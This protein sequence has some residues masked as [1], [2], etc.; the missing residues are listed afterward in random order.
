MNRK[1]DWTDQQS[2]VGT[3]SH[4][5]SAGMDW[6]EWIPFDKPWVKNQVGKMREEELVE[7]LKRKQFDDSI[8]YA[9]S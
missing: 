3:T 4:K 2:W 8:L 9:L 5:S 6:A 1:A 7:L